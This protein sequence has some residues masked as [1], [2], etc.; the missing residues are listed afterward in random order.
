MESLKTKLDATFPA[1]EEEVAK[2]M[3]K[4]QIEEGMCLKMQEIKACDLCQLSTGEKVNPKKVK[5]NKNI[6][7]RYACYPKSLSKKK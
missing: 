7:I 4:I 5:W 1:P 3:E 2:L 6:Q